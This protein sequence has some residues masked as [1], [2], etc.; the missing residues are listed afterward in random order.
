M[1]EYP[2]FQN[3][4]AFS[5]AST[6]SNAS[7]G[8][9]RSRSSRA[10]TTATMRK[11]KQVRTREQLKTKRKSSMI[12]KILSDFYVLFHFRL[13]RRSNPWKKAANTKTR[14]F[15]SLWKGIA[16]G[17]TDSLVRNWWIF[18]VYFWFYLFSTFLIFRRNLSTPLLPGAIRWLRAGRKT[19]KFVRWF[20]QNGE[21]L[22]ST[23]LASQNPSETFARTH[24]DFGGV[25][26]VIF[27]TKL[28]N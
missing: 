9:G 28:Y 27:W 15:C 6:V 21:F 16:S 26:R 23:C 7:R 22:D 12:L 3:S 10:S 17:L 18:K 13:K 14:R 20:D 8:T 25:F 2:N 11:R 19:A 1:S 24:S 4:D 5:D